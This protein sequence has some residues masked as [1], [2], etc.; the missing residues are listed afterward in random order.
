MQLTELFSMTDFAIARAGGYVKVTKHPELP[1]SICNY[2]PK[3]Q[4]E[5][6]WDPITLQCRGLIFDFDGRVVARP[7]EKFHNLDHENLPPLESWTVAYDKI[8][9]SLGIIFNYQNE[10]HVATRGSFTSDQA[11]WAQKK[12]PDY[13]DALNA[14]RREPLTWLVEIVYPENRIVCNYDFEGLVLLGARSVEHGDILRPEQLPW[15]G[16]KSEKLFEGTLLMALELEPREGAEGLVLYIEDEMWKL[17]QEDYVALHRLMFGLNERRVWE[18][19]ACVD[20]RREGYELKQISS[21]IGLDPKDIERIWE[22]YPLN[23]HTSAIEQLK[24]ELPEEFRPWLDRVDWKLS[25]QFAACLRSAQNWVGFAQMKASDR[26]EFAEIVKDSPYR[27]VCFAIYDDKPHRHMVW[28]EIRPNPTP[29]I[30]AS[31]EDI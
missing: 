16:R 2:T 21:G 9:G 26:K 3:A 17:K 1:L 27:S 18:I 29:M 7:F 31:E 24:E 8:D 6:R 15:T 11:R 25:A 14:V 30:A 28:K 4:Y 22:R 20:L 5:E 12:L 19:A 13:L 10:W 23:D